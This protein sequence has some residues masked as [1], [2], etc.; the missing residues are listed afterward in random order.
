MGRGER[1]IAKAAALVMAQLQARGD[2][3]T[4]VRRSENNEFV[5]S[6]TDLDGLLKLNVDNDLVNQIVAWTN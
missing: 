2:C 1:Q 4:I 3:D 6:I 5:T